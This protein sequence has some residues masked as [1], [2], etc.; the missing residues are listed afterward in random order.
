[1]AR[2]E[3]VT[4]LMN[5]YIETSKTYRFWT[6]TILRAISDEPEIRQLLTTHRKDI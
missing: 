3:K 1:M 5:Y 6:E 2:L 4:V